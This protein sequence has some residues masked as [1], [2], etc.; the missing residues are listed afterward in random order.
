MYNPCEVLPRTVSTDASVL[1]NFQYQLWDTAI[2]TPWTDAFMVADPRT[3]EALCGDWTYSIT[4]GSGN[5][6]DPD[7]FTIDLTANTL[8]TYS[9][10]FS[11]V[12]TKQLV[13]RGWHADWP[14]MYG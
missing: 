6:V 9:E 5:P 10:V 14:V 12:G 11:K 3:T 13:F 4:D 8:T 7:I 1:S 2:V